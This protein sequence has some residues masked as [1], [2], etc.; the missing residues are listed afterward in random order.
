MRRDLLDTLPAGILGGAVSALLG[1]L[2]LG[3][4]WG[5]FQDESLGYFHREVFMGSPLYK[6]KIASL[7]VLSIVPT[8][9][10][11]YRRKWD[12]FARG[13]ML[14]MVLMVMGIVYFQYG[15]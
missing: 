10:L 3:T 15:E 8:F 12:Q 14:V 9:H 1:Y 5:W 13:T 7:C 2:L 4:A 11:A 6:D